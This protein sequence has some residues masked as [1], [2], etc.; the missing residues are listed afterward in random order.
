MNSPISLTQSILI[1]VSVFGIG[2][3][4]IVWFGWSVPQANQMKASYSQ[5]HEISPDLEQPAFSSSLD[6]NQGTK[7]EFQVLPGIGPVLAG[8]I[9]EHR[10]SKGPFDDIEDLKG[11]EGIGEKKLTQVRPYITINHP[12][13]IES[14]NELQFSKE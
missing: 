9:I 11:V 12:A 1:K 10:E 3:V 6:I 13:K 14:K 4:L 2:V 7:D 5:G 8:R